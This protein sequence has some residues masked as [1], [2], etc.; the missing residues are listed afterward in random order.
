MRYRAGGQVGIPREHGSIASEELIAQPSH[1]S[2]ELQINKISALSSTFTRYTL[3]QSRHSRILHS[4]QQSPAPTYTV[5]RAI[6]R[7]LSGREARSTWAVVEDWV[8]GADED[9]APTA[10]TTS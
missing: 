5:K 8:V 7:K 2:R 6:Y 1:L 9:A 3:F 4:R 10:K